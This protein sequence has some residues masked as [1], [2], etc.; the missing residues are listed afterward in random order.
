KTVS[1]FIGGRGVGVKLLYDT[2][3]PNIDPLSPENI[4]VFATGPIT[5]TVVPLSGRHIV[6]SKSP[7]TGT[8]F[9]SSAGGFFGRELRMA[10]YD[11]VVIKGASEKPAYVEID[12]GHVDIKDATKIWG[13]NV[14]ETTSIL[15]NDGYKVSCIGKAGEKLIPISSIM[16]E[17]THACGRGGLGAV[18]GS[19][20]LKA[21]IVRGKKEIKVSDSEKMKKY[22]AESMRLLNASPVASKGLAY[23]GTPSLVNLINTM[24]IMPTDNFRK[25]HFENAYK[26]S[27]E[28]ISENYDIKKRTCYNCFIACKREDRK[29]NIEIPEYETIAMFGPNSMNDDIEKIIQANYICNDYGVDTISA[30]NAVSCYIELEGKKDIETPLKE[31]VEGGPLSQGSFRY[32]KGKGKEGSSMSVKRLEIPGYDPRGVLGL[33]L[34]YATSNRGAC[35]LRAYM[36]G[37]EILGKPK[38]IDRLSFSGKSGLIQIFQNISASVHSLIMCQFSSFA[39]SEEEYA[40]LLSAA[41]GDLYTSEEFIKTG[42]RIYNLERLFNLREDMAYAED[43][44]PERFFGEDGISK[45]EFNSVLHEYYTYRGWQNGVP[46][47]ER[48]ESLDLKKEGKFLCGKK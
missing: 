47:I 14:K 2:L 42:E 15:S 40:N 23:Y 39:L 38:L 12:D 10:G 30:G 6:V 32:S 36:V 13:K 3:S 7:L 4:M 41:V 22:I 17:Y 34:S 5:G 48:L 35:H 11:V 8:I 19:K 37:P 9:D 18:M 46:T 28:Y 20:K 27:G 45:E 33:A 43:T 21:F 25:V 31:I 1:K 26:V 16:S 29:R 24:R 44:L